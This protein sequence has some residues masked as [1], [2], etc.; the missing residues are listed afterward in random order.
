[1]LVLSRKTNESILIDGGIRITVLGIRGSQVRLG[2]EAPDEVGIHREEL[3]LQ[4]REF[5]EIEE[6]RMAAASPRSAG[7]AR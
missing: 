4:D 5:E 6:P 2:L 7:P 3:C 1:M